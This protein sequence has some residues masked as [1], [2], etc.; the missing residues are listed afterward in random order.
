MGGRALTGTALV[1]GARSPAALDIAR[2]FAAAGLVVHMA[3]SSRARL[4]RWSRVPAAVHHLPSPVRDPAGFRRDVAA[5]VARLKPVL[6]IPTC[7]EVF[8]LAAARAEGVEVGS[9]FAPDVTTLDRLHAKDRF[10][11]LARSLGLDAPETTVL[12]GP[13]S[14]NG[15]AWSRTVLKACYSRFGAATL[16]QPTRA[17]AARIAPSPERPWIA[18]D[19]VAGVEHSSYAVTVGGRVTAFAAYRST[20]R[21]NGGAGYA[22]R[23]ADG[24][25]HARMLRATR[26]VAAALGTTGQI[27]LDAIDDGERS[28]LIECNPR[29]TSGAHML[30]GDGRLARAMAGDEDAFTCR[31]G[32]WYNLPLMLTHGIAIHAGRSGLPAT[33]RAGSDI[34]GAPGDRLPL[35]GALADTLG[36][37]WAALHDR[38]TLTGAT[39]G[40]IEWNGA[41]R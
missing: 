36:F 23:T 1:T 18:Q 12:T 35:L 21:L 26:T 24:A 2:D 13:V 22:F 20:R 4:A 11:E 32:E 27:A 31:D 41:R 38:T 9:L 40:D 5:L 25:V 3:D 16:V 19:H 37:A 10:N 29:A 14:R 39:T 33:L 17:Q 8:H 15:F 34:V 7:E 28:W 6:V 30:A